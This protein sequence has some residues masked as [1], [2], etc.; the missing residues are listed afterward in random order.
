MVKVWWVSVG[1]TGGQVSEGSDRSDTSKLINLKDRY[2]KAVSQLT[3]INSQKVL[4]I[5]WFFK[6]AKLRCVLFVVKSI[7]PCPFQVYLFFYVKVI[8]EYLDKLI[9]F[10]VYLLEEHYTEGLCKLHISSP[11]LSIPV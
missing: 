9:C 6:E 2:Y 10:V 7:R 5:L 11:S 4:L 3:L 8:S 1:R